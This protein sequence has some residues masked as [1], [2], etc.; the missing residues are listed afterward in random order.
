[1]FSARDLL[2]DGRSQVPG[3]SSVSPDERGK[4]LAVQ[5]STV[6]PVPRRWYDTGVVHGLLV[7]SV[8]SYVTV[9]E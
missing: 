6:A 3:S 8:I 1:M 5:R 4:C 2:L 7:I 9:P